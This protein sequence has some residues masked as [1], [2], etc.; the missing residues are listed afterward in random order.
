MPKVHNKY[1]NTAPP[2]AVYCGRGSPWGNPFPIIKGQ[3]TRDQVC[4]RF[5]DE[6]L[7]HLDVTPLKGKDLVCFCKPARCHCDDILIKANGI[8]DPFSKTTSNQ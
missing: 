5:R 2:D 7:P 4:D 1:H 6:I 8:F 3:A